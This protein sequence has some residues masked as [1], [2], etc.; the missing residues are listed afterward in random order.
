MTESVQISKELDYKKAISSHPTYSYNRVLPLSGSQRTLLNAAGGNETLFEIPTMV[1][2][3]A[4]SRFDFDMT[5]VAN[6]VANNF[7]WIYKDVISPIRQIQVYTR[8]GL[9]LCDINYFNTYTKVTMKPLTK[10]A[11]YL[12][13][14][15]GTYFQNGGVYLKGITTFL[16]APLTGENHAAAPATGAGP[17]INSS[18]TTQRYDGTNSYTDYREPVYLDNTVSGNDGQVQATANDGWTYKCSIP[19]ER[20]KQCLLSLDKDLYFGGEV[21][22]LRIVWEST[23]RIAWVAPNANGATNPLSIAGTPLTNSSIIDNMTVYLAIEKNPAISTTIMNMVSTSGL[24]LLT[25]YIY[26]YKFNLGPANLQSL[27]LRLNRGHGRKLKRII[28]A[29]FENQETLAYAY[30]C[31]NLTQTGIADVAA[32]NTVTKTLGSKVLNFYSLLNNNRLQEFNLDCTVGDDYKYLKPYLDG[33]V[34][35]N[36]NIYANNWFWMDDFTD[37]N[38]PIYDDP[39]LDVGLPLDVEQKWDIYYTTTNNQFNHYAFVITQKMLT[40]NSDGIKII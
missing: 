5:V 27:S 24:S 1:F 19:F 10:L 16:H 23:N 20:I 33:G 28:T 18:T 36:W 6:N 12:N 14:D 39:N 11:D 8:A 29:I 25:D 34:L 4:K 21:L 2:N 37:F 7:T 13:H 17:T 22:I 30:E 3:F 31:S 9:Y 32:V 40:I 35:Q 15:V 38:S 26:P